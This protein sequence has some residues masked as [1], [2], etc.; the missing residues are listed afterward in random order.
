MISA[1]PGSYG[2]TTQIQ[3][4]CSSSAFGWGSDTPNYTTAPG[5]ENLAAAATEMQA[6]VQALGNQTVYVSVGTANQA[7]APV[8]TTA[9]LST[10]TIVEVPFTLA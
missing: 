4:A 1:Q 2:T 6:A 7:S 9:N 8:T 10:V 5:P 3:F